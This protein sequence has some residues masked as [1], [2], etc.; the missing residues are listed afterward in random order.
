ALDFVGNEQGAVLSGERTRAIP[1]RF[2]DWVDTALALDGFQ[3][4]G[5]DGV[6]EFGFKVADVVEA[7]EL[8]AGKGRREGQAILLRRSDAERTIGATVK[9]IVESEDAMLARRR[10]RV[11]PRRV[12]AQASQFQG[13]IDGFGPAIGKENAVEAGPFRKFARERALI[14]VVKKIRKVNGA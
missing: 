11:F 6:V 13:A 3:H 9:R 12:A 1:E 10:G 14:R 2:A 7:H 8:D 5:A 4:D